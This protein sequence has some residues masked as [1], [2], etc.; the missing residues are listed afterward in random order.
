MIGEILSAIQK[1]THAGMVQ[2]HFIRGRGLQARHGW[3]SQQVVRATM[4]FQTERA[5]SIS[6]Y[7]ELYLLVLPSNLL[8]GNLRNAV[9]H[10]LDM[11]AGLDR[12]DTSI[13]D[14]QALHAVDLQVLVNDTS[15]LERAHLAGAHGVENRQ[16]S[17]AGEL[18]PVRI[19]LHSAGARLILCGPELAESGC[20]GDA[21][22]V[23]GSFFG[24]LEVVG[25][26]EVVGIDDGFAGGGGGVE[27]DAAVSRADAL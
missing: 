2:M 11:R 26:G 9:H 15:V 13:H 10:R 20:V 5:R 24:G 23:F 17:V 22:G 6:D 27:V 16:C 18:L 25:L 14:P 21:A 12:N 19:G 3:T 7:Y 1:R 8:R 4:Y